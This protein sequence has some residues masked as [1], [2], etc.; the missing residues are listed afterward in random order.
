MPLPTAAHHNGAVGSTTNASTAAGCLAACA[1][2]AAAD[3]AA[4]QWST[5]GSGACT[6]FTDVGAYVYASQVRWS[7]GGEVHFFTTL[8]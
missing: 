6:L 2:A 7:M 8:H 4:W 1:A 3:C 5:T